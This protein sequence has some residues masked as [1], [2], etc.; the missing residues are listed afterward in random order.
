M[1]AR[2]EALQASHTSLDPVLQSWEVGKAL[3]VTEAAGLRCVLRTHVGH[4]T[5]Q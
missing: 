1:Y 3:T 4:G 2:I 5:Q